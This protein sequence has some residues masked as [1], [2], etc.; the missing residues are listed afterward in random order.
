MC[1]AERIAQKSRH[2]VKIVNLI[3]IPI[4]WG[5]MGAI[6]FALI[7]ALTGKLFGRFIGD[8]WQALLASAIWGM[9][10]GYLAGWYAVSKFGLPRSATLPDLA[11][12][13]KARSGNAPRP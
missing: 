9:F 8:V 10:L 1:S 2:P 3:P 6:F 11:A 7:D 12:T 13:A 5:L 4:C